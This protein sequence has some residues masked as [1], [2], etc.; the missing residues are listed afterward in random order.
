MNAEARVWA[1]IMLARDVDTCDAIL[2][3]EPVIAARL[4]GECLRRALRGAPPPPTSE[5]IT[6]TPEMLEAISAAGP[7]E[8]H[9]R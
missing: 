7:L 9:G 8:R 1:A 4:D 2:A 3:G 5:F 6:V